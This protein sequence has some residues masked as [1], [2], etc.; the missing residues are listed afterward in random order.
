MCVGGFAANTI[1]ILLPG[2]DVSLSMEQILKKDE[3]FSLLR[4]GLPSHWSKL[5]N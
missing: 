2:S 4:T 1:D 3:V 5:D